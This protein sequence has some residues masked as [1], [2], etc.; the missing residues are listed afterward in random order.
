MCSQDE[1]TTHKEQEDDLV[2]GH[3]AGA[4]RVSNTLMVTS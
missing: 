4:D 1:T 2:R 3:E